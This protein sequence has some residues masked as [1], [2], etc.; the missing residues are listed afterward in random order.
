MAAVKP[1][2]DTLSEEQLTDTLTVSIA[3]IREK[4]ASLATPTQNKQGELTMQ[5]HPVF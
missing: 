1:F 2:W 4:A 3:D 5:P